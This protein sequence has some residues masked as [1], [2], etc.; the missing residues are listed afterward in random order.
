MLCYFQRVGLNFCASVVALLV[1]SKGFY[2]CIS[3]ILLV[4]NKITGLGVYQKIFCRN[5]GELSVNLSFHLSR[6]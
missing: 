3:L 4:F 1:Q 5:N 6:R 2:M